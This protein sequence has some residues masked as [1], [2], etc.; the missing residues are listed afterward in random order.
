[1]PTY[2]KFMKEIIWNK[3]RLE[4]CEIVMLSEEC[5]AILLN[6]LPP[7][8]KDPWSFIIPCTIGNSFFE[9]P[10]AILM[11]ALT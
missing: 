9:N 10:N 11:L 2:V 8:L 4:K 3:R 1:M 7:M 6:K 5:S